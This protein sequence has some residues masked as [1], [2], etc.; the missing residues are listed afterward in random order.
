[1]VWTLPSVTVS[2]V[3]TPNPSG[4]MATPVPSHCLATPGPSDFM[5]TPVPSHCL[6]TPVPSHCLATP[7]PSHCLATPVPSHVHCLATSGPSA[8]P[9]PFRLHA[10][11]PATLQAVRSPIQEEWLMMMG[12]SQ[13]R[14]VI[15]VMCTL[16][17]HSELLLNQNDQCYTE[18]HLVVHRHV[19]IC[20]FPSW[21]AQTP[22]ICRLTARK[23]LLAAIEH[24]CIF[25]AV[26]ATH[27]R[28]PNKGW[29]A[30]R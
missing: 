2:S 25:D 14:I 7:V 15:L 4:R 28:I 13:L 11:Q 23:G 29:S 3:A 5:A 6:A 16:L 20:H 8:N 27:L 9:W 24:Y 19:Q 30:P 22:A 12:A 21:L 1:M 10:W 18:D 17:S 26:W